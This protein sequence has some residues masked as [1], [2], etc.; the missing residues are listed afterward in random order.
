MQNPCKPAGGAALAVLVTFL[1][2][3]P[4]LSA[5]KPGETA[6]GIG[7]R[8][9]VES[10]ILKEKRDLLVYLPEEYEKSETR[11]PVLFLLDGEW[12]FHHVSGILQFLQWSQK[13]VN[14]ILVALP[15][16]HRGRD[17]SPA[18]W[19]GYSSYTGGAPAFNRFL[20]E[21]L[22]PFIDET[23]RTARPYILCGHSLAGTFTL[24]SFLTKPLLF[25]AYMALSPCLFWHDRFML[26]KTEEFLKAHGEMDRILYIAHEYA[27]GAPRDTL[28][29]FVGAMTS[30]APERLRWISLFKKGEDHF[31]YVHKAIYEGLDFIFRPDTN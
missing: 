21:E 19:P 23:F 26:R 17:F 25:D 24:Y 13:S 9:T 4:G 31:S 6:L 11:F 22:L 5:E 29:E 16:T 10:R 2:I 12:H 27:G 8:L 30:R 15:N 3:K 14:L 7:K 20:C 28:E 18:A 1:L